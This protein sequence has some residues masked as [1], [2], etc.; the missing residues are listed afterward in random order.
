MRSAEL[1]C[2]CDF[3]A[4]LHR[5]DP[6]LPIS[7][8]TLLL[9]VAADPGRPQIRYSQS[10]GLSVTSISRFVRILGEGSQK[11]AGLG[12]LTTSGDP[13]DS[14]TCC[15]RLSERGRDLLSR[16]MTLPDASS[17]V[18]ASPQGASA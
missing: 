1:E 4:A 3:V 10:P 8:A 12:L 17:C 7:A 13:G 6:K 18:E 16:Y 2:L 9:M 14:R 15:L 5:E 11:S